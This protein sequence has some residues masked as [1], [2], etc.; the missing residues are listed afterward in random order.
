MEIVLTIPDEGVMGYSPEALLEVVKSALY[1]WRRTHADP[2]IESARLA[3]PVLKVV[4][5]WSWEVRYA[6]DGLVHLQLQAKK[7]MP[8]SVELA[9]T[10]HQAAELVVGL[11]REAQLTVVAPGDL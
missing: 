2:F 1:D 9:L 6:E 11:Y 7:D 10:P 3:E 4:K 8:Y 5:P